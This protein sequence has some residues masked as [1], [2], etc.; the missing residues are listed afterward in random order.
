MT[1]GD[2]PVIIPLLAT[3]YL[4]TIYLLLMLAQRAIKPS[5]YS[6][7]SFSDIYSDYLPSEP[8]AQTDNDTTHT[9]PQ[10][11]QEATSAH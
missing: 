10:T 3:G 9:T 2:M 6:S 4:L 7:N 8:A 5:P 11:I 1:Y